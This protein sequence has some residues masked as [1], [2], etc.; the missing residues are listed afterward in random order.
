[1]SAVLT[2]A[3]VLLAGGAAADALLEP[4]DEFFSEP[5]RS[6]AS[7]ETDR[8]AAKAV[9]DAIISVIKAE[10]PGV[11]VT[12]TFRVGSRA[13]QRGAVDIAG[14]DADRAKALSKKLG[15]GY[16]T[17]VESVNVAKKTQT[18]TYYCDGKLWRAGGKPNPDKD[19][20]MTAFG[21][22]G[23]PSHTHIQRQPAEATCN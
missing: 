21:S 23:D 12:S 13:H 5:S 3:V 8:K 9:S 22:S 10:D 1:M 7:V 16:L 18:N 20:P 11:R 17:I 2:V 4:G 14:T 15:K 6:P 19:V